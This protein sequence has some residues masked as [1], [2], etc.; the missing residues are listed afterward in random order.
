MSKRERGEGDSGGQKDGGRMKWKKGRKIFVLRVAEGVSL[1]LHW[2]LHAFFCH[3]HPRPPRPHPHPLQPYHLSPRPHPETPQS[4]NL[5]HIHLQNPH[6]LTPTPH[7]L[8]IQV[9]IYT[10]TTLELL[11]GQPHP[12]NYLPHLQ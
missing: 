3:L 5:V 12:L 6:I 7:P 8:T 9:P 10:P 1:A 2:G 11:T 4:H